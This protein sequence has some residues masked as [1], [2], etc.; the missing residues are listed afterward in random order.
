[1]LKWCVWSFASV[2]LALRTT[3]LQAWAT[4]IL[5]LPFVCIKYF[6]W[7]GNWSYWDEYAEYSYSDGLMQKRHNSM[8]MSCLLTLNL[9]GP[10]NLGSTRSIAWLLMPW[11]L[12]SPGHQ[13]PWYWLYRI[14]RPFSYLRKYLSTCVKSMWRND[15]QIYVYVSSEKIST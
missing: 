11:L 10:S 15:M 3:H 9:L 5:F 14:C 8:H 12:M 13:Q 4:F 7:V 1:M 6:H 2:A